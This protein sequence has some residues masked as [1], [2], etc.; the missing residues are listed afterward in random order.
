MGQGA[1]PLAWAGEQIDAIVGGRPD[2]HPGFAR[3]VTP[4]TMHVDD[5][6]VRLH[7]SRSLRQYL[8]SIPRAIATRTTLIVKSAGLLARYRV[9]VQEFYDW[10]CDDFA[11]AILLVEGSWSEGDW[12]DEVQCGPDKLVGYF[13]DTG[14]VKRLIE[15]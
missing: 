6:E 5:D 2:L 12:P 4:A 3:S 10:F 15:A 14:M 13:E 8:R 7:M 9:G 11:M 1:H